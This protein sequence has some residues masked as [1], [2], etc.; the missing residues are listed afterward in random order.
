MSTGVGDRINELR[1]KANLT[2]NELAEKLY[3]S[4]KLVCSWELGRRNPSL[5][6][7]RRMAELFDVDVYELVCMDSSVADEIGVCIPPGM[8]SGEAVRLVNDF[9]RTLDD[10]DCALFVMRYFNFRPTK[11]ISGVLGKR[12]GTVRNKLVKIRQKLCVFLKE[13]NENGQ[14]GLI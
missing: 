5:D 1:T 4:R 9:L 11:E 2:Q 3:V 12:D 13:K 6:N 7:L 14:T 10:E 8:D